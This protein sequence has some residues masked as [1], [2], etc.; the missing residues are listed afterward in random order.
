VSQAAAESADSWRQQDSSTA[1]SSRGLVQQRPCEVAGITY[2]LPDDVKR[3]YRAAGEGRDHLQPISELRPQP[4][5]RR[6][7]YTYCHILSHGWHMGGTWV[8]RG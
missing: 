5:T 8:A 4:R 1:V 7:Q 3:S 6:Q 2:D